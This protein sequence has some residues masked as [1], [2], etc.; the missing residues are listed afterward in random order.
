MNRFDELNDRWFRVFEQPTDL[1]KSR[2]LQQIPHDV[3]LGD[4][5]LLQDRVKELEGMYSESMNTL[6]PGYGPLMKLENGDVFYRI[7]GL[8]VRLMSVYAALDFF[9]GLL[10]SDESLEKKF[11][12]DVGDGVA[13]EIKE[14][15]NGPV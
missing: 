6:R 7:R 12:K 10:K 1:D 4:V 8:F 2:K 15:F 14:I 3:L 5:K 11:R 13:N 9:V